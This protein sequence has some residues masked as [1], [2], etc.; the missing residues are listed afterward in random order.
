M[1]MHEPTPRVARAPVSV[2]IRRKYAFVLSRFRDWKRGNPMKQDRKDKK[3]QLCFSYL[4][5][6]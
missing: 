4:N 1:T 3:V 2:Q 6:F 5:I